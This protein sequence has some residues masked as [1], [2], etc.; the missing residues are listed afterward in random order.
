MARTTPPVRRINFT[1]VGL[2][3]DYV[4]PRLEIEH[5]P[6]RVCCLGA[7]LEFWFRELL[8]CGLVAAGICGDDAYYFRNLAHAVVAY[9]ESLAGC[10]AVAL[11]KR[12]SQERLRELPEFLASLE[13]FEPEIFLESEHEDAAGVVESLLECHQ[14][15][16]NAAQTFA[17]RDDLGE[18]DWAF[19]YWIECKSRC[20]R[21]WSWRAGSDEDEN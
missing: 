18:F 13:S 9:N 10:D 2:S 16:L 12:T 19:D 20:D 15:L 3:A 8:E 6:E 21:V 14:N 7:E 17:P 1:N 4:F 5:E 11:Q